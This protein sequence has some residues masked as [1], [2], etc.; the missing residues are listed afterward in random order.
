MSSQTWDYYCVR[1]KPFSGT[2]Y[3]ELFNQRFAVE[4]EAESIFVSAAKDLNLDSILC[5]KHTR[6]TDAPGHFRLKIGVF[7]S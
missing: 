3:R 1:S 4:P 2:E 7:K 6:K 5:V